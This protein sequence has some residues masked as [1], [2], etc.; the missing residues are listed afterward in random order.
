[1]K[2]A[3][4][5]ALALFIQDPA[6]ELDEIVAEP[7]LLSVDTKHA[8]RADVGLWRRETDGKTWR[9]WEC[10]PYDSRWLPDRTIL[11]AERWKGRVLWIDPKGKV[12]F[13]RA[14]L[15]EPVDVELAHDG[16]VVVVERRK[17][18]VVGLDPETGR[19]VWN[20][21]GFVSP[22][23]AA[24]LPNGHLLVADSDGGRVVEL[25]ARG[26]LVWQ[27]KMPFPNTVEPLGDGGVLI[28]NW[29]RGEVVELG[30]DHKVRW[31]THV[32]GTLYSAERLPEGLT[33]VCDGGG[34]RV[35]FLDEAGKLIKSEPFAPGCVDY[36]T[37]LEL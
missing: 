8:R 26:K 18:R 28:S 29:T 21:T 4:L 13:E 1:M 20:R 23:D 34:R 32:G 15:A 31:K 30:P 9:I 12:L 17:S 27:Y 36:E 11:I 7:A 6:L 14:G 10:D 16:T 33:V 24:P 25:D 3:C 19:I 5:L 37:I 2:A 35:V 22:F